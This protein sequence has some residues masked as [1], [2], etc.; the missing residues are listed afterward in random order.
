MCDYILA[1]FISYL[2]ICKYGKIS[3]NDIFLLSLTIL[4]NT[5]NKEFGLI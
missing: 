5:G 2:V 1:V 3:W 4:N